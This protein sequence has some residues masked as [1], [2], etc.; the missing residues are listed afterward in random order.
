VGGRVTAVPG[1]E[2]AK[3]EMRLG[4][5]FLPINGAGAGIFV[6]KSVKGRPHFRPQWV[7]AG[8]LVPKWVRRRPRSECT[9]NAK[10]ATLFALRK[11]KGL[12]KEGYRCTRGGG[13]V[14][15]PCGKQRERARR[16][17]C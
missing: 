9:A 16:A 7:R 4:L 11:A 8:I 12:G 10:S 2:L 3:Q 5:A 1:P 14:A 13:A 6:V 15:E 17:R